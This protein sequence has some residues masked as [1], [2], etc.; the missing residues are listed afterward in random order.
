MEVTEKGVT[1]SDFD[2]RVERLVVVPE[3]LVVREIPRPS[4]V[5]EGDDEPGA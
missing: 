3:L 2:L 4:P 5:A 1:E